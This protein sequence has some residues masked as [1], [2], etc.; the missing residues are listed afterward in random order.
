MPEEEKKKPSFGN[1]LKNGPDQ[2]IAAVTL[3]SLAYITVVCPCKELWKCHRKL[4]GGLFLVTGAVVAKQF[5]VLYG[6]DKPKP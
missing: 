3:T 2:F 1:F 5:D 6:P 4:V